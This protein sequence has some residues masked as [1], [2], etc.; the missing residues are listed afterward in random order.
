MLVDV[1]CKDPVLVNFD[2]S[3]IFISN[4]HPY[5]DKSFI[6]RVVVICVDKACVDDMEEI[7][8]V[9]LRKRWRVGVVEEEEGVIDLGIG[10]R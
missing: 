4:M 2:C 5:S 10:N 3:I 6:R 1:K 9:K 8:V 7:W